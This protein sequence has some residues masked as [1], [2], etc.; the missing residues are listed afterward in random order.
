M[1]D[2]SPT[3]SDPCCLPA[4]PAT[5]LPLDEGEASSV[6]RALAH[7][8]RIRILHLLRSREGCYCGDL[9]DEIPLA[10]STIS[11][12]LKVLREAGLVRGTREGT[13]VCYCVE[14]D[15]LEG[16]GAWL[17]GF[18]RGKASVP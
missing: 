8:V 4:D 9:C 10:Q 17:D 5:G 3:P 11:Q 16:F 7:P 1:A 18:V 2:A 12:H 6:A 14:E 13:A 15:R